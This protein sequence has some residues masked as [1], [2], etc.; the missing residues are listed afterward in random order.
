MMYVEFPYLIFSRVYSH[1][2]QG[3]ASQTVDL[4]NEFFRFV[5]ASFEV[6]NTSAPHIYHSALPLSPR[7]ST[8]HK[9]YEPYARPLARVIQG[10][11]DA[12]EPIVATVKH[13][14]SV[15]C[16]AWSPCGR[17]I[18]VSLDDSTTTI[19]IRDAVAL[20]LLHTLKS[21]QRNTTWLSFSPDSRLLTQFSSYR[22]GLTTWDLQTGG[23]ISTISSTPN[24]G[25]LM[26]FSS[27]HS[28][29]GKMVAVAYWDLSNG[30]TGTTTSISTYNLLSGTHT[31][32]HHISE[33]RI[34]ASIWTRGV[35]LRFAT[36]KPGSITVWEAEFASL[37]TLAKVESL[38]APQYDIDDFEPALFAPT[39]SRLAF[40]H[41]GEVLIW[42]TLDSKLLL[43]FSDDY[44]GRMFVFDGHSFACKSFDQGIHLW[45][46]SPAGYVLHRKLAPSIGGFK[47][48]KVSC[49][50]IGP[51]LSPNG[52]SVISSENDVTRLWRTTDPITSLPSVPTQ[53]TELANFLLEFSPDGSLA[54]AARLGENTVTVLDLKSGNQR[55][56]VT[57]GT[58]IYGLRVTGDTIVVV[59]EG[60]IITWN[61]PAGD[62]VFDARATINDSVRTITFNQPF[63]ERLRPAPISPNFNYTVI[64]RGGAEGLDICDIASGNHLAG[65]TTDVGEMS[66]ITRDGC[67]VWDLDNWPHKGWKII[68]DSESHIIGLER[69]PEDARPS[70]GYPWTSSRGHDITKDGWIFDSRKERLLWLPHR[71]RKDKWSRKW[72]GRFF[73][74]LD[75]ELPEPVIIELRE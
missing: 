47:I 8:I 48:F 24:E 2:V 22:H 58:K 50:Q 64:T 15:G 6:I 51:L 18:A 36:V 67:E 33:G 27:T 23:Q 53:F 13:Y 32:S 19:E 14:S 55:L 75:N 41:R 31:Y 45:R 43:K 54:A 72:G 68:K 56:I 10:I 39:L 69:L 57:T 5:I 11:P 49:T 62:C 63:S 66:W 34:V 44:P 7:T 40:I 25:V 21:P 4:V 35:C 38:P 65:T 3:S 20:E 60:R 16:A 59:G 74:L 52:E 46:D 61:L 37:H 1:W 28:I 17:Y 30:A 42:D 29:D 26:C 12:W 9:L 71:W 73:G 70:G